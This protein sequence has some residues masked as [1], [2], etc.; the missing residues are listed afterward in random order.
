[1][2]H[3]NPHFV[4]DCNTT[5][6]GLPN[7]PHSVDYHPMAEDAPY[8][9]IGSRLLAIRRAFSDLSQK[10]WAARHGF[11]AT[12]YNNWE[13][14]IRRIPVDEA[15]VLADLY[16]LDLDFIYRGRRSGLSENASK[17]L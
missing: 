11:S 13:T 4:D 7:K 5:I 3:L 17:A 12:R 6:C 10:D 16:G 14:G 1:M 8:S 15:V 9:E 2:H